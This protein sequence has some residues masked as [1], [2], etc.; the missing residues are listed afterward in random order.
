MRKRTLAVPRE[1][2]FRSR[3]WFI[4]FHARHMG[5]VGHPVDPRSHVDTVIGY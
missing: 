2:L 5:G 1:P 3:R 4:A